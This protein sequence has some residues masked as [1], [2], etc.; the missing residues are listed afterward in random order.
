MSM[1]PPAAPRVTPEGAY[2]ALKRGAHLEYWRNGWYGLWEH[3]VMEG[4]LSSSD[5][6]GIV[7]RKDIM[8]FNGMAYWKSIK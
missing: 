6:V 4:Y 8:L 2:D 3:G 5:M 1:A 7:A